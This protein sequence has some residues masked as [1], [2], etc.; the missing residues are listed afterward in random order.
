M[1]SMRNLKS[2]ISCNDR[3]TSGGDGAWRNPDRVA[4]PVAKRDTLVQFRA[5]DPCGQQGVQSIVSVSERT[6]G[7]RGVIDYHALSQDVDLSEVPVGG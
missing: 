3:Y 1:R 2:F 4:L 6:R 7:E 5:G